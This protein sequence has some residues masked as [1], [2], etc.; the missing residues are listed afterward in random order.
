[1][2]LEKNHFYRFGSFRLDPAKRLLLRGQ[3]SVPLM[4]KAFDTLLVL[5]ENRDRMVG[6][7][8]LMKSL[9]PDSF[10]EEANLAQN[11]AVLRKALGDSP[12][13]HRYIVTIPGRGYRFAAKVN[14][15]M[16]EDET[17]LVVERHSR[18]RVLLEESA[19]PKPGSTILVTL[20]T[21]LKR[22]RNRT[23]GIVAMAAVALIGGAF[24]LNVAKT[25]ERLFGMLGLARVPAR[26]T[27]LTTQPHHSI[28]ILP[29]ENLS[30]DRDQ[31]YF[32]EGMT[33]ELT[34]DLAQFKELRV[35]SR[36]SAMHYKG[37]NKTSLQVGKE[38][39]VDTLIE[40]TVER[41]GEHV[42]IRAQL[43]DCTS[44]RHL[45]AKIYD[46]EFK[47]VLALQSELARDI[48]EQTQGHVL[49]IQLPTRSADSRPVN[50]NAY[51]AYLRGR[52]FWNKRTHEG[53]MRAV[54]YFQAAI[55]KDPTYAQAFAGLADSY[56]LLGGYGFEEQR[57]AMSKARATALKALAIDD[58]LAEA[59]TSLALIVEQYDWN[60]AEA[61]KD[62][63]RA[64]ELNPN[65]SVAH[66][67]YGDGYL[68]AV[69][70]SDEAI[71]ELR[72]A[73]E[74]DPLSLVI[75]TDL[76]KR[77]CYAGN[78][79]EGIEQF[80]KV[81]EAD[82]DFVVAHYYLSQAYEMKGL[83]PEAIAE[84]KKIKPPNDVPY[85]VAQL[86][87][88]YALQGRR[89]EA[90][91]IAEQL[92]RISKRTHINP[93]YIS[94][95]YLALGNRDLV[96]VWLERAYQEHSSTMTGLKTDP[97]YSDA[98]RSD[99]RFQDL[100]RRVGLVSG[101]ARGDSSKP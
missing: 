10:V 16:E 34:S 66:H 51:E 18:S 13:E 93:Y 4:P 7:E 35:I 53:F 33:D 101:N 22:I 71:A 21:L 38:L 68:A 47:D 48:V 76:A 26:T 24:A 56:L 72:R 52:Y 91:G 70:K 94:N 45:W 82:P 12:E 75:A 23:R 42:R 78:Y 98:I 86:G 67:W 19:L 55:D 43:I 31:D 1:M 79:T 46:R 8:E 97:V 59:Y 63:K 74:L 49:S 32:A 80:R 87:H 29:L 54:Q 84:A 92:Q 25:R 95:I 61:E 39:G 40:G 69:G 85:S 11:V 5:V 100:M 83:F 17:D 50:P 60:W 88:I 73:H 58:H 89:R 27:V 15:G 36:T 28:A 20:S 37:T 77:L 9:W 99:Q 6:K 3:K 14:E 30:G 65:Y 90:L 41:V 81:L 64:I 62:Y 2:L 44:D 57:D 96:F